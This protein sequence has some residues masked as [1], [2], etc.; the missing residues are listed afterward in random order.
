MARLRI[1]DNANSSW[2]DICQSE[3]RIKQTDG[4][5]RR[6]YPKDLKARHGK[7]QYWCNIN[8]SS[9]DGC[10]DD[11]YGGIGT[12]NPDH[13]GNGGNGGPHFGPTVT[14]PTP[15]EPTGPGEPTDWDGNPLP[16]TPTV[17][18]PPTTGIGGIP[19]EDPYPPIIGCYEGEGIYEPGC[20]LGEVRPLP[21]GTHCVILTGGQECVPMGGTPEGEPPAGCPVTR[22]FKKEGVGGTGDEV[23]WVIGEFEHDIGR[24]AGE[25]KIEY[26]FLDRLN[27]VDG[28]GRFEIMHLGHTILRS[29]HY[30][31][32]GYFT[33]P[34]LGSATDG[35]ILVRIIRLENTDAFGYKLHCV[36]V[37]MEDTGVDPVLTNP[38]DPNEDPYDNPTGPETTGTFDDEDG[39]GPDYEPDPDT[40]GPV[41][42]DG[43]PVGGGPTDNPDDPGPTVEPDPNP[44]EPRDDGTISDTPIVLV[45]PDGG[46]P[47]GL[48]DP[49]T[50]TI[51]T[52]GDG[53]PDTIPD[54]PGT[55]GE[56][57][58]WE[59]PLSCPTTSMFGGGVAP[60]P[61]GSVHVPWDQGEFIVSLGSTA[62][63]VVLSYQFFKN[64]GSDASGQLKVYHRGGLI[65]DTGTATGAGRITF[66]YDPGS[67]PSANQQKVMI[68]VLRGNAH[69]WGYGIGCPVPEEDLVDEDGDGIPDLLEPTEGDPDAPAVCGGTYLPSHGGNIGVHDMFHDMG[70]GEGT[71]LID[72]Q[73]WFQPDQ[74]E[75]WY[76][77]SRIATTGGLVDGVGQLA[78]HFAPRNGDSRLLIRVISTEAGTSWVYILS[79]PG[80]DGSEENPRPCQVGEGVMI[81]KGQSRNDMYWDFG[82]DPGIVNILYEMYYVPDIM[83][84]HDKDGTLL[85]GST[86]GELSGSDTL[87]FVYDPSMNPI[88]ISM[89]SQYEGNWGYQVNCPMANPVFN[90]VQVMPQAEEGSA[91]TFTVLM[92][93]PL[94][95]AVTVDY[96]VLSAT[97]TIGQD[98]VAQTGTITFPIGSTSESIDITTI[99]DEDNE[100]DERLTFRISNPSLGTI[101]IADNQGTVLDNDYPLVNCGTSRTFNFADVGMNVQLGNTAGV[102]NL[103]FATNGGSGPT[104]NRFVVT[105]GGQPFLDSNWRNV[106]AGQTDSIGK[107]YDPANYTS[108]VAKVHIT[109]DA[110]SQARLSCPGPAP[111]VTANIFGT[112]AEVNAQKTTYTPPTQTEIFNTWH[113]TIGNTYFTSAAAATGDAAAWFQTAQGNIVQPNNVANICTILNP[114]PRTNYSFEARVSSADVDNDAIGLVAASVYDGTNVHQLVALRTKGGYAPNLG[115]GL[116]IISSGIYL[117][118]QG[119]ASVGGNIG[120]WDGDSS[121]IK[122]TRSGNSLTME[123]S[124]WN[125]STLVPSSR[126]T[127]D[128]GSNPLYANKP[129]SYG[130]ATISQPQS[131]YF[132][133]VDS[134]A[135]N[136]DM[137]YDAQTGAIWKFISGAWSQVGNMGNWDE[138]FGAV[139][140]ITNPNTGQSWDLANNVLT[141]A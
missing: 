44:G 34:Y 11:P 56:D 40:G 39:Y 12:D 41:D 8:C 74:L 115:W 3:W 51:D 36:E 10:A 46:D 49:N 92:D 91:L 24:A 128:L 96:E 123:C 76:Q 83:A 89:I 72:Y 105:I 118:T 101:A 69:L 110:W 50:P 107:W 2:I 66:E 125:S 35:V 117:G 42:P 135:S 104:S 54:S 134:G 67:S 120:G 93:A 14:N 108:T 20:G 90:V 119:E 23:S 60:D 112:T 78:F 4:T 137:L 29:Q 94:P 80:E 121:T 68:R 109:G 32:S 139:A 26:N 21:D 17:P 43:N 126:I 13:P 6:V 122:V 9:E 16:T 27:G 22:Q 82:N 15:N 55:G 57:G 7:D 131:T 47:I 86:S 53:E 19:S 37:S 52:D 62:G 95:V 136:L 58:T 1:R 114:T 48:A 79:C 18:T 127:Y 77:G 70:G 133:I 28:K 138:H 73:M 100:S 102:V 85:A 141:P 31:G 130:Y 97:A 124:S 75:V 99:D 81:S 64:D 88:H 113:R 25:L 87:S 84:V 111:T 103:E 38:T 59:D 61:D 132:D 71:V 98:F 65:G 30:T 106:P 45:P 140:T 116:R 129:S 5:W 33:I 63:T